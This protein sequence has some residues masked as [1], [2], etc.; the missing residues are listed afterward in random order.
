MKKE[1]QKLVMVI[2][3]NNLSIEQSIEL[4]V[5]YTKTTEEA[6]LN[7]KYYDNDGNINDKN[8][9]INLNMIGKIEK[10]KVNLFY[11]HSDLS[12]EEIIIEMD[13]DGFRPAN[14]ME[15]LAL[16]AEH[17]DLQRKFVIIAL[18]STWIDS[19]NDYRVPCLDMA[20]R[21]GLLYIN[22]HYVRGRIL[23]CLD[24]DSATNMSNIF[25]AVRK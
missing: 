13:K 25:L 22:R 14:V 21:D 1:V 17:P 23:K 10:I 5:D 8:F 16:G 3:N 9:P 24:R 19:E 7:G 6:I 18:G 20:Y 12:S 11:F 2:G 4:V 15:L